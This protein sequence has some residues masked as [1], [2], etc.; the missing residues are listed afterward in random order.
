MIVS[1]QGNFVTVTIPKG[2]GNPPVIQLSTGY[3]FEKIHILVA[4]NIGYFIPYMQIERGYYLNFPCIDSKSPCSI[5][6][7]LNDAS[8]KAELKFL[9][10]KFGQIPD[11]NYFD[12]AF[13]PI[14]VTGEDG[15]NYNVIPSDQFK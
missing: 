12:K 2:E 10:E 13:D 4:S 6:P 5:Q 9:I 3:T 15:N 11:P 1:Y 14:L 7:V 8:A